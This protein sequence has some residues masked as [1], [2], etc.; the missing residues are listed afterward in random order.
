MPAPAGF[1]EHLRQKGYHPRSSAHGNALCELVLR[2]LLVFCPKVGE[3]ASSGMLVYDL[4]RKIFVGASQWNI[5]L[6]LGPPAGAVQA[7]VPSDP[8]LRAPPATIRIAIEA[9]TVMTEHGKA[10]RNRQRDLDSFHQFTHRYDPATIAAGLTVV[11]IARRFKSPLRPM[12]SQ[13]PNIE[14]LVRETLGLLRT[15]PTRAA[16]GEGPGLEANGAIVVDHDNVDPKKTRLVTGSPA[17]EVGDPLH[18]DAFLRQICDRYTQ[19]WG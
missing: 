5:D 1:V 6:V 13:H 4:N 12:I 16:P 10:R 7:P 17:P 9:K 11:N 8:I 2:D 18:Y 3:H 15:L 14:R 19:R